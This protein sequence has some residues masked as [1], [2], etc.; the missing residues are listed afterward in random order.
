MLF[1]RSLIVKGVAIE[2]AFLNPLRRIGTC[3]HPT[4]SSSLEPRAWHVALAGLMR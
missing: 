2:L 3:H 4:S 1:S